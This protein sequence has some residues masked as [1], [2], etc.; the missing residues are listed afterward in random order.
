MKSYL[1]ELTSCIGIASLVY[2]FELGVKSEQINNILINDGLFLILAI[3]TINSAASYQI[4]TRLT[5]I[6]NKINKPF[7]FDMTKLSTL[8]GIYEHFATICLFYICLVLSTSSY[9]LNGITQDCISL[10]SII[11][12]ILMRACLFHAAY[13]TFDFSRS[14]IQMTMNPQK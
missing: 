12:A 8:K 7:G 4:V 5:E 2:F 14:V 10:P 3:F 13:C 6:E 11:T 1:L 9:V